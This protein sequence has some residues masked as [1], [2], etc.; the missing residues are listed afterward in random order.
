MAQAPRAIVVK[1]AL[2]RVHLWNNKLEKRCWHYQERNTFYSRHGQLCGEKDFDTSIN[3]SFAEGLYYSHPP[4]TLTPP[5]DT[6]VLRALGCSCLL[7][8]GQGPQDVGE[9]LRSVSG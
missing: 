5:R 1:P 9:H 8:Q 4:C 3:F 6:P 2:I 7:F